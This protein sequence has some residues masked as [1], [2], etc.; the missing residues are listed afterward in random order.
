MKVDPDCVPC[1]AS[2]AS[3]R[4][5]TAAR[6]VAV[7]VAPPFDGDSLSPVKF[8]VPVASVTADED[9]GVSAATVETPGVGPAISVTRVPAATAFPLASVTAAF[10]LKLEL[11]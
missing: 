9:V 5:P 1:P 3:A 11:A 2:V 6:A 10:T 8:A 4:A 7:N